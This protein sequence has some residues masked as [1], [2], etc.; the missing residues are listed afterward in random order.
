MVLEG[1]PDVGPLSY[2][3]GPHSVYVEDRDP[4]ELAG[5]RSVRQMLR[6]FWH[7]PNEIRYISDLEEQ[8]YLDDYN[9]HQRELEEERRE[10]AQEH[11]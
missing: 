2:R 1:S 10:R 3:V 4:F 6:K 11:S 5:Y 9:R 7:H 8:Q